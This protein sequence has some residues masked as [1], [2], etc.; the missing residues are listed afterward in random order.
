MGDMTVYYDKADE[1]TVK[2]T[3]NITGKRLV[4]ISGSKVDG[5]NIQAA[6]CGAG[7][8]PFGAAATDIAS[9]STGPI[10]RCGV[11]EL[12]AAENITAGQKLKVAANGTVA[13]WTGA[14]AVVPTVTG[15]AESNV[16]VTVTQAAD[17][18]AHAV[19]DIASGA[20]GPC[21]L[22]F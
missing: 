12:E 8:T 6:H 15:D 1:L 20:T 13:V 4:K 2:A 21:A 19:A 5:G 16:A 10:K 9:G 7:E 22:R 11:V 3:A 14:S 18:V 17:W